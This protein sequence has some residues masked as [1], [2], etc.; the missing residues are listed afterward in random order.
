MT[1]ANDINVRYLEDFQIGDTTETGKCTVTREMLLKF[2]EQYDPQPMHLDDNAARKSVF[3]ELVGSGWLTLVLTMRLLVDARILG[4]T[5]IVGVEFKDVRFIKPLRPDDTLQ[6]S[7]EVITIRH[8][9]SR[10]DRG[11]LELMV[12]TK[13]SEGSAMVTQQWILVAPCKPK[14]Y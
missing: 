3:G 1:Q 9:K 11:F 4:S 10:N 7:A 5:P 12:T 8:S 14:L 6:V 2:A 13:N